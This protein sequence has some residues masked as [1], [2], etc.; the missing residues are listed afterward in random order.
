MAEPTPPRARFSICVIEDAAS[1]LLFLLRADDRPL[2]PGKW[3][4]P[5]GHI[6]DGETAEACARR[7]MREEIGDAHIVTELQRLG[8]LRDTLWGGIYELHLFHYRWHGGTVRL[9]HEHVNHAWL[10]PGEH[11]GLTVMDGIDEDIR[12][13]HVWPL[14]KLNA[15]KLPAALRTAP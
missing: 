4:F 14:D 7:E 6:E 5:A 10:G 3:G 15:A 9:N 2:A 12:L 1:R 13:L 11:L 8:P